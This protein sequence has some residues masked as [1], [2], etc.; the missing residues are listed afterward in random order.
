MIRFVLF[1]FFI[2]QILLSEE[3][4]Q[5]K[6]IIFI[7]NFQKRENSS[8][9]PKLVHLLSQKFFLMVQ[10]K[11]K[12]RYDVSDE[13]VII[14]LNKKAE[15]LL[16]KNCD[17]DKCLELISENVKA[18]YS[19][20]GEI[21]ENYQK[22]NSF[23]FK[24][25]NLIRDKE[26]NTSI[27]S[28]RVEFTEP[29]SDALL[30]ELIVTIE[31]PNYIPKLSNSVTSDVAKFQFESLDLKNLESK[32]LPELFK[33]NTNQVKLNSNEKME[34]TLEKGMEFRKQ[35]MYLEASKEFWKVYDLINSKD[36]NSKKSQKDILQTS[37]LYFQSSINEYHKSVLDQT[38]QKI[39]NISNVKAYEPIT[40]DLNENL[41]SYREYRN[42]K[43]PKGTFLE[44]IEKAYLERIEWI[45]FQTLKFTESKAD[46]KYL[47]KEFE[48]SIDL[49]LSIL[50]KMEGLDKKIFQ[51][52]WKTL[53]SQI[54]EKVRTV[55]QSGESSMSLLLD[56][57][58]SLG[59]EHYDLAMLADTEEE[60]NQLLD[61][62]KIHLDLALG[63]LQNDSIQYPF[64]ESS[65]KERYNRSIG[66]LRKS[67]KIPTSKLPNLYVQNLEVSHSKGKDSCESNDWTKFIPWMESQKNCE[68]R[69]IYQCKDHYTVFLEKGEY[70]DQDPNSYFPGV[71]LS[72]DCKE[73]MVKK[74]FPQG[75][76]YYG[77]AKNFKA[78]GEGNL[79]FCDSTIYRGSFKEDKFNGKGI[80]KWL[81]GDWK[82]NQGY[83]RGIRKSSE[84]SIYEGEWKDNI[85]NGRG[86]LKLSDGRTYEGDWKDDQINGRGI[87]KWSD[88]S[89]YEG[90]WKNGKRNG[91]G[92]LKNSDSII[93]EGDW[94]DD[95]KH[96]KGIFKFSDGIYEG[97]WIDDQR[98]GRGI[99][100]LSDG[101]TYEGDWKDN[102]FHG[103]G[104]FK[105]SDGRTYEG[106]WKDNQKHG[107][108]IYKWSDGSIYEGDWKDNQQ[109]GKGILKS[110]DGTIE[111]D[112]SEGLPNGK[113]SAKGQ[114]NIYN[115][116]VYKGNKKGQGLMK[117]ADGS[118]YEGEWKDNKMNG[119]GKLI[120]SNG[121]VQEGIWKDDVFQGR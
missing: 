55:Y 63:V 94:K 105:L 8:V 6:E 92:I 83:G 29:Q 70:L 32:L 3:R 121:I 73:G 47:Q 56:Q 77:S 107:K 40:K 60:R 59:L 106:D 99:F 108:G 112:W 93:Y 119:R 81:E 66:Y 88:G 103:R 84:V 120:H 49:Y 87:Y 80:M 4:F 91:K 10:N 68:P 23:L 90:D 54:H 58:I 17:A 24:F 101:G 115:G 1:L 82:D 7:K 22:P 42:E 111:G 15:E 97:D 117:W 89:I 118:S 46:Q 35:K 21:E 74:L 25:Q 78:E 98:N 113:I 43:Y 38:S 30:R 48:T 18:K 76:F 34:K 36:E 69:Q 45:D 28:V 116:E 57:Y 19:L 61:Q 114:N 44:S 37:G 53:Q 51:S 75:S 12:D 86:Y 71:C 9:D 20:Y 65:M 62:M 5:K 79:R 16:R 95:Q 27:R 96:G 2:C 11:F 39:E 85:R 100:K 104:Y 13:S 64:F 14:L 26:G 33:T 109:H 72:G 67:Q 102:K 110:T 41:K 50:R 52:Q 31:N